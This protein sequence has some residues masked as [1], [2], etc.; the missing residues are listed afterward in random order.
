M[1]ELLKWSIQ[2]PLSEI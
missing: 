1:L 2:A